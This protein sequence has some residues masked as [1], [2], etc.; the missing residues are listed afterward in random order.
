MLV[1]NVL[2]GKAGVSRVLQWLHRLRAIVAAP[3]VLVV[4]THIDQHR[5]Q[6]LDQ[7]MGPGHDVAELG[8]T[9]NDAAAAAVEAADSSVRRLEAH[10]L[11]STAL[12]ELEVR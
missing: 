2:E 10:L 12:V 8:G 7:Y 5:Q 11:E 9:N 1:W 6:H 3:R 4:G